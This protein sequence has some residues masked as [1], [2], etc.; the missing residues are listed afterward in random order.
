MNSPI[1]HKPMSLHKEAA[2]LPFRKEMYDVINHFYL[3]EDTGERFTTDE[4]DA[5]NTTQVYNQYREKYG[6]PFP[7]EIRRIREKY[8]VSASKMS[9][10][11]GLGANTYRLYEAGEMPSVSNGRLILSVKDPE[12]FRR[13][14]QA[15]AHMLTEKESKKLLD[16]AERVIRDEK[17]KYWDLLFLNNLFDNQ[18][19]NEFNGYR[20]PDLTKIS[21]VIA[22]Y[23]DRGIDLFKTKLNKLLFY[24]DFNAFQSSGFSMTGI[25]Y[26]AIQYGPVPAQY[27]KLLVKLGDDEKITRHEI[28]ITPDMYGEK[29]VSTEPFDESLFT[30]NEIQLLEFIVQTLGSLKASRLVEM[31]HE[32]VGW[33]QNQSEKAYISYSRFAFDLKENHSFLSNQALQAV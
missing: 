2:A 24:T 21:Q 19:P 5:L 14:V 27:E 12:E 10:I 4:L 11:L 30:E 16:I 6:I 29:I 3:C 13:Q 9:E 33:L 7:E 1:T 32:E 15:S 18:T 25:T 28:Q 8:G 26:R 17:D 23:Q 20:I 31:S 22:F